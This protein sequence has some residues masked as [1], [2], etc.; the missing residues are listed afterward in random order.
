MRVGFVCIKE[1]EGEGTS[2]VFSWW[3]STLKISVK[4]TKKFDVKQNKEKPVVNVCCKC[5]L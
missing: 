4:A 2:G 5:T 3:I 1:G